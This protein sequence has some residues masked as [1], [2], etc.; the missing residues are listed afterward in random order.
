MKKLIALLAALMMLGT[1]AA[2][3]ADTVIPDVIMGA[4]YLPLLDQEVIIPLDPYMTEENTPNRSL[5][6]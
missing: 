2:A 6:K 4:S 3:L 1:A 5:Y